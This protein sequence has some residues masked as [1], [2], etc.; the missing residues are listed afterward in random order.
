L[1]SGRHNRIAGVRIDAIAPD[2]PET[3]GFIHGA[4]LTAL[5]LADATQ[6]TFV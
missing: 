1:V 6:F 5:N 3:I 4:T 2:G